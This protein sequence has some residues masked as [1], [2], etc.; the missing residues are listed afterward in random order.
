MFHDQ[1]KC[2]ALLTREHFFDFRVLPTQ[3]NVSHSAAVV[4]QHN[5]NKNFVFT[6]N[7][8]DIKLS[9]VD[10][11]HRIQIFSSCDPGWF[12][13]DDVCINF[14]LCPMCTNNQTRD[15]CSMFDGHLAYHVLKNVTTS[16]P[17]NKLDNNTKLSLFWDMFH[18]VDDISPS[19]GDIF[20]CMRG[21]TK[22]K[23][24]AVNGSVLCVAL[25]VRTECKEGDIVLSVVHPSTEYFSY[26]HNNYLL[27]KDCASNPLKSHTHMWSVIYQ[28][29]FQT[30]EYV[31]LSLCEKSVA[32]A[33]IQTNCSDFY[34]SSHEGTCIRDSLVCDGHSHCPHG[35]DEADCQHICSD[36]SHNCTSHCHHR[37]LCFCLQ[38]YFQCL[39]GGCVPLQKLCDKTVHCI[40]KSDEQPTCVYLRPEQL[41]IHSLTLDINS[42]IN[43]LIQPNM[44][45]QQVC[46]QSSNESLV[47]VQNVEYMIHS[48]QQRCSESSLSPD[49]TFLCGIYNNVPFSSIHDYFSLDRLCVYDQFCDDK[50]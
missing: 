4:C 5:V 30:A 43:K 23:S 41:S 15:Q 40:D 14:Y 48:K 24:F 26:R 18:N 16:T 36:H 13:V 3:C 2:R 10:G 33:P 9:L 28:P 50:L 20:E 19:G 31:D 1:G 7:M 17:G 32:H 29:F 44:I 35:E 46:L 49:R 37:D 45:R 27:N 21:R 38:G 42:Y 47:H 25:N 39:S 8:S 22:Q 34:M 6:S 12:M 11:Y